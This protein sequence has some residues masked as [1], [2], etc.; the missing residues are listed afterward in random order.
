MIYSSK[1]GAEGHK[2]RHLIAD[3]VYRKGGAALLG[4]GSNHA[5]DDKWDGLSPYKFS[6]IIESCQKKGYF[7][8]KLID[9]LLLGT[10]PIYWGCPNLSDYGFD[11]RGIITFENISQGIKLIEELQTLPV[12]DQAIVNNFN[13]AKEYIFAE[14]YIYERYPAIFV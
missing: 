11:M 10:V 2:L 3:I 7:S 9:C 5:L 14:D 12:C 1:K 8:E 6:I 13:K 4:T